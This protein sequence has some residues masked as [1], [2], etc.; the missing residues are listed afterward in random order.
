VLGCDLLRV[1]L[2]VAAIREISL[3][4]SIYFLKGFVEER[5]EESGVIIIEFE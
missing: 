2:L 3:C 5:D 1:K 4:L